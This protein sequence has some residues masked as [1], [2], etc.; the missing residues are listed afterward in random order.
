MN[1]EH[2]T[3][4]NEL[5][6]TLSTPAPMLKKVPKKWFSWGLCFSLL[7]LAIVIAGG[8]YQYQ[9][10]KNLR[11]A[12]AQQSQAAAQLRDAEMQLLNDNKAA[13]A[14]LA[15]RVEG[16]A[17]TTQTLLTVYQRIN[18]D[19]AQRL[20]ADIAQTLTMASEALYIT[21]DIA[22]ALKLLQHADDKL[23]GANQPEMVKLH[24]ALQKDIQTL[25][26]LPRVDVAREIARIDILVKEIDTLPLHIDIERTRHHKKTDLAVDHT[27]PWWKQLGHSIWSELKALVEIRRLDRPQEALLSVDQVM[28]VRENM[29]LRLVSARIALMTR[30]QAAYTADLQALKK[31]LQ[32]YF[33]Q[34]HF[35]TK[36]AFDLLHQLSTVQLVNDEPTFTS[37]AVLR[38]VRLPALP[39]G[40]QE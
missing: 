27:Q 37:L 15:A 1:S 33:D 40:E 29:K 7:A 10:N 25:A 8:I 38:T 4:D 5:E 14:A 3:P 16:L 32:T 11:N 12:L 22:A 28:L 35:S 13:D 21:H 17:K 19:E 18:N 6:N 23:Q 20:L 24:A 31:Y 9:E 2:I 34:S 30:N 26:A 39:K 36:Q